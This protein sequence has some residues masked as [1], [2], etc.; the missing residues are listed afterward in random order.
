MVLVRLCFDEV[1][2]I[3]YLCIKAYESPWVLYPIY[4]LEFA[5]IVL[6]SR[7]RGTTYVVF[8]VRSVPIIIVFS[9]LWFNGNLFQDNTSIKLLKDYNLSILYHSG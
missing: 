9:T 2:L 6:H 7:F 8:I 3:Y 4:D 5:I 1:R